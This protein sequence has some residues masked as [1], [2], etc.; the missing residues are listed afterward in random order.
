MWKNR[1]FYCKSLSY[2]SISARGN[3]WEGKQVPQREDVERG[4]GLG[5]PGERTGM[6]EKCSNFLKISMNILQ[7]F[8]NLGRKFEN[9]PNVFKFLS[10][11]S[12][13]FG[14]KLRKNRNMHL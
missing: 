13:K 14:Q 1:I 6:P 11:F 10:N 7:I 4:R 3:F 5:G 12:R 8:D 9:F 2:V